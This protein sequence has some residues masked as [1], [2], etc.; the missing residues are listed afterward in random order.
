MVVARSIAAMDGVRDLGVP[1]LDLGY[2]GREYGSAT[3]S[4]GADREH[5]VVQFGQSYNDRREQFFPSPVVPQE[6]RGRTV[7]ALVDT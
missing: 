1:N 6:G 2:S 7:C 5:L 4:T 3:S